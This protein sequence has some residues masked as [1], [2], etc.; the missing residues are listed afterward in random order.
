MVSL[1]A[2]YL[3][4][5]SIVIIW[6]ILAQAARGT[7]EFASLRNIFLAGYIIF[8]LS[9]A[10]TSLLFEEYDQLYIQ[11]PVYS[12]LIFAFLSTIFLACFFL[13]YKRGWVVKRLGQ[14]Q[15]QNLCPELDSKVRTFEA[16]TFTKRPL[17][18]HT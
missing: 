2:I 10:S 13:S 5:C 7:V 6:I 14:K 8:Q 18:T 17:L 16:G 12:G 15:I 3:V 1:I 9:S 4:L 11:Y